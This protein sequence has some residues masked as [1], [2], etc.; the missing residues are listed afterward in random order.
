[1]CCLYADTCATK[2]ADVAGMVDTMPLDDDSLALVVATKDTDVVHTF[3]TRVATEL[4]GVTDVELEEKAVELTDE[5]YWAWG[6]K[7][8]AQLVENDFIRLIKLTEILNT[9]F[10]GSA[11]YTTLPPTTST[12]TTTARRW[13]F[14]TTAPARA[15]P[16][17]DLPPQCVCSESGIVN[18]VDTHRP[19]CSAHLGRGYGNFCYIEGGNECPGNIRY[20]R[21]LG[22]HYRRRC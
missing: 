11:V 9:I 22:V 4:L 6:D 5:A 20:S 21:S 19:G 2:I 15:A 3:M 7:P 12:T 17:A 18:G 1:M 10:P 16:V 14:I 8:Q 13:A